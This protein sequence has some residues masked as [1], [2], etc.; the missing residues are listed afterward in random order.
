V[1]KVAIYRANIDGTG[2]QPVVSLEQLNS[3]VILE[4]R[5]DRF[6][7]HENYVY[8]KSSGASLIRVSITTGLAEIFLD[9]AGTHAFIDSYCYYI[10][11]A[12][13]TFSIYRK[14]IDTGEVELIRGD[15]ITKSNLPIEERA[16]YEWYNTVLRL[17]ASCTTQDEC[18]LKSTC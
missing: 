15:G 9:D 4:N 17:M 16:N 11:H 5:I 3:F 8:I 1:D 18:H 7:I 12:Q 10:E 14:D 6:E 13:R 2:Q